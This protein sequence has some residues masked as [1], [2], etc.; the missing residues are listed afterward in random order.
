MGAVGLSPPR[1]GKLMMSPRGVL[2]LSFGGL[3]VLMIL[4]ASNADRALKRVEET[5][6]EIRRGF[7][8]RDD[9]LNRLRSDLYRSGV[10][11]RDY[12]LHADPAVA[13]RRRGD[14]ERT[15][16]EMNVALGECRK[17]LPSEEIPAVNEL[18]RDV[19]DYWSA[20]EPTLHWDAETRE[21]RRA[22]F[23]RDQLFPRNQQLLRLADGIGKLDAM[24][25]GAGVDRVAQV[26][27]GF[28][29]QLTATALVIVLLGLGLAVFSIGR[30]HSLE[31]QAEARFRE[32]AH[33]RAELQ[34]L[35][36]RLV[37]AQEEERR[38]L[39]R[40]LHDEVGQAMSAL[41]VE[42]S[43]L[44]AAL[45]P[46]DVALHER[47]RSA[48]K[49]AESNVG[50]IRNMALLLR[51]SMLDD[52]GLVP[53]L[54]WQARE[55]ARRTGMKIKVAAED[56]SDDLPDAYRTCIYRVTQEALNNAMRHAKAA[57]VRITVRQ[58]AS[59]IRVSIQDDGAGFNPNQEKGMGLLGMEERVR[60]LGGAFRVDS[61]PGNG[62]VISIQLPL[63]S[64]A[65]PV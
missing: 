24:Q 59:G 51:P 1:L 7:L 17:D 12:L 43:N 18:E 61:E 53:A 65:V 47:L 14:L 3:L 49:L 22:D 31:R 58:E 34:Q 41:L 9:A 46:D 15:R 35:S 26:F 60:R 23:L 4:V 2:W 56:V 8:R 36:A 37:A 30:I 13:E 16:R 54:K 57:N 21:A 33:A 42:L 45:P 62:T 19:A 64:T 40:E 44:E 55:T 27:A 20:V 6:T 25:L 38:K 52:L 11:I 5:N 48:R 63:L 32:V 50:S 29:R 39:S 10:E 28:R